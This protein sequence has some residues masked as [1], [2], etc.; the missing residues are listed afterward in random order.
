MSERQF[1]ITLSLKDADKVRAALKGLG[2]D[3]KSALDAL[4]RQAAPAS[5]S[6]DVLHSG[7]G[8]VTVGLAEMTVQSSAIGMAMAGMGAG[9]LAAGAALTVLVIALTAA[10]GKARE[11]VETF[12]QI[13]EEAEKIGIT[14]DALQELRYAADLSGVGADNMD[15]ALEQLNIRA[16]EAAGGADEAK[17]TFERLGISVTDAQGRIKTADTILTELA[18]RFS[19]IE[20]PAERAATASKLFGE[21]VG[22]KMAAALAKGTAEMEKLRQEARDLGVVVDEHVLRTAAETADKLDSMS[23]VIDINLKKAMVDLAPTLIDMAMAFAELARWISEVRDGFRD[24]EKMSDRGLRSRLEVLKAD[25]AA[26]VQSREET[27]SQAPAPLVA[28]PIRDLGEPQN[29]GSDRLQTVILGDQDRRISALDAQIAEIEKILGERDQNRQRPEPAAPVLPSKGGLEKS[30]NFD[31]DSPDRMAEYLR[32]LRDKVS[33]LGQE[34]DVRRR[35]EAIRKASD[36]VMQQNRLLTE[37]ERN[38]IIALTDSMTSY[39]QAVASATEQQRSMQ[40]IGRKVGTTLAQGLTEA[41][42]SAENLADALSGVV[43]QL[44]K[45]ALTAASTPLT[46]ALSGWFGGLFGGGGSGGVTAASLTGAVPGMTPLGMW[47][48]FHTGGIAGG[49]ATFNRDLPSRLW[50]TAPR[51]HTGGIAGLMPGEVPAVLKRGEGIF[52]PEQM[53]A[54]GGV[55][56]QTV[57][58]NVVNVTVNRSGGSGNAAEDKAMAAEVAR[59]VQ[60]SLRGL[61]AQ[62]LLSQSRPGGLLSRSTI[63]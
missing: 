45:I 19:E 62:E 25:R 26:T 54:L 11:A 50:D 18:A 31:S 40:Q 14:T 59:Q 30:D 2:E 61:V 63:G 5:R 60:S 42:M 1:E 16:G 43:K 17:E 15:K 33:V 55:G 47:Q 22:A 53:A 9:S 58:N 49:A 8:R 46:N 38:E 37:D 39:E 21:E 24:L 57:V 27:R 34:E 44:A 3:G 29:S 20:S 56:G 52:T 41:V 7:I 13:G 23:R 10:V 12:D 36:I 28:N 4:E 51:Y 32:D 35:I 6:M 48:G